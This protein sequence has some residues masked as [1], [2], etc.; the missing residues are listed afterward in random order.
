MPNKSC[1]MYFCDMTSA[2]SVIIWHQLINGISTSDELEALLA[3]RALPHEGIQNNLRSIADSSTFHD[4]DVHPHLQTTIKGFL[5]GTPFC[6]D[7][8]DPVLLTL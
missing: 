1:A 7:M 4:M 3:R 8:L 6:T 2:F 5:Q